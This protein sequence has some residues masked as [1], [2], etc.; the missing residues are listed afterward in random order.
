MG[1]QGAQDKLTVRVKF[2]K[3]D[4]LCKTYQNLLSKSCNNIGKKHSLK[5]PVT[6]SQ[7]HMRNYLKVNF[8]K[9]RILSLR[10]HGEYR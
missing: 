9:F 4:F 10:S 3:S 7:N 6:A 2:E 5:L 8:V 1:N